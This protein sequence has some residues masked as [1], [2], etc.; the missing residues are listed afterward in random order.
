M[1]T[2]GSRTSFLNDE[3]T[4]RVIG[5][6][7]SHM[8]HPLFPIAAKEVEAQAVQIFINFINQTSAQV[9][10]LRGVEQTLENRKL[11]P[12]AAIYTRLG[13]AP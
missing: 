1:S 7:C 11:D 8:F 10:P 5:W 9:S 2:Q 6:L 3:W 12:L 4:F 13:N